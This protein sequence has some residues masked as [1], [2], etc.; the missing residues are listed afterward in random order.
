MA[1]RTKMWIAA[2]MKRLMVKKPLDKI[3]VTEICRG[4]TLRERDA[5]PA[6]LRERMEALLRNLMPVMSK[7]S[8][9]SAKS[10]TS[11]ERPFVSVPEIIRNPEG[12]L[13]HAC[14]CICSEA[15]SCIGRTP[16]LPMILS[17]RK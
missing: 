15:L 3:R 10:V 4:Y 11:T 5:D 8:T 6:A 1:E 13:Y 12:R 14:I 7:P 9:A 17:V 2:A 16:F